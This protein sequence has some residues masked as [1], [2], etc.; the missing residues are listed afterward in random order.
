[1]TPFP[2]MISAELSSL[3]HDAWIMLR[4]G[5]PLGLVFSAIIGASLGSFSNVVIFRLPRG[6]S[7]LKPASHCPLC[8]IP[9]PIIHNVPLLSYLILHGRSR[10][11]N[12][13][14]SSR[15]PVVELLGALILATLYLLDGWR[16]DFVFHGAWMLLLLILA[17]IDLEHL[18]LPNVLVAT[19][20]VFSL[21][22]MLVIPEQSWLQ[23]ALGLLTGFALAGLAMLVGR[24]FKGEWRGMGD[25]KLALVLGFPFGPGRFFLLYLVASKAA[26]IFYVVRRGK[27]KDHRV[28]MGPFFAFGAWV[29]IWGGAE[30]VRWYL[31]FF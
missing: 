27:L 16:L 24:I 20:A 9:I 4:W 29:T 28:P 26:I 3:W 7:L 5:N 12:R 22:W 14:I 25:L 10:C 19:G 13:P 31:G 1:M 23:A 18:R 30:V 6:Q 2:V 11:C 17:A 21:L 8:N 15:Y